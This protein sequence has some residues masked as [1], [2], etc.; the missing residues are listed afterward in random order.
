MNGG[1]CIDGVDS[2]ACSCSS[3]N[4]GVLCQCDLEGGK[5][6][7]LPNWFQDRPF[8]PILPRTTISPFTSSLASHART[9]VPYNFTEDSTDAVEDSTF[10]FLPTA[11]ATD[12]FESISPSAN[13]DHSPKNITTS[14][15]Q[16]YDST[17][18]VETLTPDYVFEISTTPTLD[19]SL[20]TQSPDDS[21]SEFPA[22][23]TP[24]MVVSSDFPQMDGTYSIIPTTEIVEE[25]TSKSAYDQLSSVYV[26]S[27]TAV[28]TVDYDYASTIFGAATESIE[29][30][31][32]IFTASPTEIV[33]QLTMDTTEETL[34][35]VTD[36]TTES[37]T[38]D[39]MSSTIST[40]NE[41]ETSTILYK[42]TT[43]SSIIQEVTETGNDSYATFT[44]E[45]TELTLVTIDSEEV[46]KEFTLW[47]ESAYTDESVSKTSALPTEKYSIAVTE[48]TT[49]QEF[50]TSIIEEQTH[51]DAAQ[52]TMSVV[53]DIDKKTTVHLTS[54][55]T[56]SITV[57]STEETIISTSFSTLPIVPELDTVVSTTGPTSLEDVTNTTP[58]TTI[59][60]TIL[61]VTPEFQ[62]FD[63]TRPQQE[64]TTDTADITTLL[65][66]NIEE[67]TT[68]STVIL[69]NTT[70]I[71]K[72]TT[73]RETPPIL[74]SIITTTPIP[75]TMLESATVSGIEATSEEDITH[76][77]S[78]S[79][80]TTYFQR[81]SEST[82]DYA[83]QSND[84]T[85][86]TSMIPIATTTPDD[87][88][89]PIDEGRESN[90]TDRNCL[91]GGFCVRINDVSIVSAVFRRRR[92]RSYK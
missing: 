90:C 51:Y 10:F 60:H 39:D 56:E 24:T 37:S 30:T 3:D 23:F 76:T 74:D 28:P 8:R 21:H 7:D 40:I 81:T 66:T 79:D 13:I 75:L 71:S 86:T 64:N 29:P 15:S 87:A 80:L 46:G 53:T 78:Y 62:S 43:Y 12:I 16:I 77:D 33:T 67:P 36:I 57:D 61:Y 69:T 49:E 84:T 26:T 2:F 82:L 14:I 9:T 63:H 4:S 85:S 44:P 19:G 32:P 42:L 47:P 25:P 6:D 5:C 92:F 41:N 83:S 55:S 27:P 18:P 22:S 50:L 91:H 72:T 58:E 1:T 70:T 35:N 48:P 73:D 34:L 54:N 59:D 88:M 65:L 38:M 20:G 52:S 89:L 31:S 45:G 68:V 11:P 17:F